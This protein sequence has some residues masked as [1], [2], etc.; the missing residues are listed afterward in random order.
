MKQHTTEFQKRN[1]PFSIENEDIKPDYYLD[2]E[3]LEEL[4]EFC[5]TFNPYSELCLESKLKLQEYG[6]T[7]FENPFISTNKLLMIL[8][9]NLQYRES[10]ND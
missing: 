5:Q 7:D 2:D 10:H 4:K 6:I 1:E 3:G 9:N 8:E